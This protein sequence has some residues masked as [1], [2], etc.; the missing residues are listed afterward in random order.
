MNV[1]NFNQDIKSQ[2]K[3]I[4]KANLLR[5]AWYEEINPF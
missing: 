3:L 1:D 2:K 5:L 4:K